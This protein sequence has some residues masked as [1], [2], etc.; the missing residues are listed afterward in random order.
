MA[1]NLNMA[2]GAQGMMKEGSTLA[3]G[4]DEA[5]LK[6]IGATKQLA[7]I[8]QS[9][10]GPNGM[11]KLIINHLGKTLVSSDCG[12]IAREL[13]VVHPAAQMVSMASAAQDSEVGDGTNLVV[14]F[15]GELLKL[16]E[17]LLRTGLHTSEIVQGYELAYAECVRVLPELE[18]ARVK[19]VRDAAEVAKAIEPVVAA[20]HE[21]VEGILSKVIADACVA[22]LPPAPEAPILKADQVRIAKLRGG[23]VASS[24]MMKGMIVM[25]PSE[26][27]VQQLEDRSKVVAFNCGVEMAT[28]ETKGTVLIRTADELINYNKSEERALEAI[29]KEIADSGVKLVISGG[30]VS[31]MAV[32]FLEKYQ[33]MCL[34]ITSKWELRRLCG[35]TGCT[36]LVR[37]GAPTP[38]EM[39]SVSKVSTKELGGR[40]VTVLEQLG[41]A[42]TKIATVVLRAATASLIDDLE[43]AVDDGV[44]AVRMLCKD[45]RLLAGGGACEMEL[46]KRLRDYCEQSQGMDHYALAKFADAFEVVPRALAETSG[47]DQTKVIAELRDQHAAGDATAGVDLAA[48]LSGGGTGAPVRD[49]YAVKESALRLAVDAAVTVLRVD[50]IIMSK[51]AGGPKK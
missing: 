41:D 18:I 31:E 37:L 50:Q 13:E 14:S 45:P 9:S 12:T 39:G 40:T 26:T 36:A 3:D 15:S 28:T 32:H 16:A 47:L 30:S 29:V 48:T 21:G 6:N 44:N 4:V 35:A 10:L 20:K 2:G 38:E 22:V 27:T 1:M 42:Q 51:P 34:K 19:N 43:R 33:L 23:D 24:T 5:V 7:K 17:E 8:V 46:S 25:R 49:G 11:K